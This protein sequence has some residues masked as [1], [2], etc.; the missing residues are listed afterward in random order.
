M[1]SMPSLS[2][3]SSGSTVSSLTMPVTPNNPD[4][5]FSPSTTTSS[6]SSS[7]YIASV[8]PPPSY[9]EQLQPERREPGFCTST[10]THSK[11]GL[12]LDDLIAQGAV[13]DVWA[14]SMIIEGTSLLR[15]RVVAKMTTSQQ[16]GEKL[17]EE[18]EIY[19]YMARRL[20]GPVG[21]RCYGVFSDIDGTTALILD[22]LGTALNSFE[23]LGVLAF[24]LF[25]IPAAAISYLGYISYSQDVYNEAKKIHENGV[26]HN[27]LEPRNVLID[28]G[29]QVHIID[30]HISVTGHECYLAMGCDELQRLARR[31]GIHDR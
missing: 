20:G 23:N 26:Y 15:R 18:G 11:A 22:H 5:P 29:G 9:R 7:H 27:D 31:L 10:S 30:F 13:G 24:V 19:R 8:L 12:F 2:G 25:F 3:A 1:S 16:G 28:E 21:P 4:I 6:L 17:L 14:G